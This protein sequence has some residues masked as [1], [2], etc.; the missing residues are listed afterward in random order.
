MALDK[1]VNNCQRPKLSLGVSKQVHNNK[2]VKIL[3]QFVLE[4]A[5]K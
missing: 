5:R 1:F 3:T 2:P 4:I